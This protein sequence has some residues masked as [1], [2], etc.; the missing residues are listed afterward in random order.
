M[1]VIACSAVLLALATRWPPRYLC[2]VSFSV[3]AQCAGHL[4]NVAL[5]I[6]GY[7]F[8]EQSFPS[9]TWPNDGVSPEKR[10]SWYAAIMPYLDD[11][12]RYALLEKDEEWDAVMNYKVGS[13]SFSFVCPSFGGYPAAGP[14]PATYIGVAGLGTDAPWLPK[15]DVRA[16]IFG[17]DR[18][19][20]FADIKDGV[21]FTMMVAETQIV[22]RSWL[23]GGPATVRGLDPSRKPYIGAGGQFGGT[24]ER[25]ALVAF[26]D[27]SV[28]WISPSIDPRV[29]E[30]MS[31]MAGGETLPSRLE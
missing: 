10:L 18:K 31:T 1:V 27:G 12:S 9:G 30:A 15:S 19:A 22:G 8:S 16:G 29:F 26:A 7:T 21:A 5:A 2:N 24:H 25:G 20:T 28:R 6:L 4:R 3:E 23:E 11:E 13:A 17:Y 14:I